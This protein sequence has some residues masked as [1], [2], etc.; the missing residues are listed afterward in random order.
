MRRASTFVVAIS[1]VVWVCG[2][3]SAG[4]RKDEPAGST[5]KP[6]APTRALAS[7][8][9]YA[10]VV[11]AD[12]PV[13]YWRLGEA[14][15]TTAADASG[16]GLS[17]TYVNG[18]SLGAP[19][20][21]IGD[22]DTAPSFDG[23]DDRV[24]RSSVT[25]QLA[26]VTIEA[27]VYWSGCCTSIGNPLIVYNGDSGANGYGI[28]ISAGFG[29]SCGTNNQLFVIQGGVT[30]DAAG[31]GGGLPTNQWT[32][33]AATRS[34]NGVWTIFVNGSTKNSRTNTPPPNPITSGGT[35]IAKEF[36]GSGG[37]GAFQGR[38]DEVAVYNTALSPA[39]IKAH[40][41]AARPPISQ[42]VEQ[43]YGT[44]NGRGTHALAPSATV[45]DP[46]NTLTGAFTESVEDLAVPG[47]G[48]SFALTRTYTSADA[49]VGRFGPGWTDSYSTSLMELG[50]G[51]VRLRG[52]EGQQVSF[53]KNGDGS[54]TAGAGV[55]STLASIAGG[56]RL[57]RHDQVVYEFDASGRLTSMNDRNGQ[58]LSFAYDASARLV[59]VT[60]AAG[61]QATVAYNASNLVSQVSLAGRSVAYGYTS[62]RLTSVTDVRGKTWT[63][64]YDA[65]GRLATIVDPLGHAQ[66]S[67]VYG[68]D[69]RV[70]SQTDAL[71]KTTTFAW[72]A[73]TQVATVTDANGKV[74]KDD[75]ENNVL[76]KRIDPLGNETVFG[77]DTDLNDTEVTGPSGETTTM[78]YDANGNV[79]SATAPASLG[80]VQKTFVYNPRNDPTSVTDARG[81]VTS[82]TYTPVGN[83]QTVTQDGIQVGSYTYGA[84]GRVLTSTDGNGKTTVYTYDANGNTA[85]VTDPLGNETSYT[86]DAAGRVLTRVD[87]R[88]NVAGANPADFTWS[89]THNA[90]GQVL[91]ETDPLGNTTTHTY[92]DAG[93]ESSLTDANGHTTTY[94]YDAENRLLS[95]R[96]P[97]PDGAGPLAAPITAYTY[98]SVGNK[99]T[100][101]DPRGNVTTFAYDAA[102]RL[103]SET[104]PDP[105][106]PGPLAGPV[107]TYAY[108][109]N[110]NLQSTVEPRGNAAGANPNEYRTTYTYDA[111]GRLLTQ[112][113][114]DP[115]GAGP[116]L[117]AVTTNTYDSVGNLTSV[118]DANNHTTAYTYDAAGGILTVTAPDG[119]LT[120]SS[121]DPAGNLLTRR[122]DNN[123][124]TTWAHDAAGRV[125]SETGPDPDGAGSAA[126]P[127]TS[128]GYDPNGN[129]VTLTDPNGNATPTAGDGRTS[130]GYDRA[131]R[132]TSIDYA[133]ATPDVAFTYDRVGNRLTM[134]DGAGTE[135]RTY[136]S[137]DRLL[138]VSRGQHTFSYAYDP[139]GNTLTRTYPGG[140][141]TSYT[142]D[143]LNRIQTVDAGLRTINLSY[144]PAGHVTQTRFGDTAPYLE[145]FRAY[146]RAGRLTRVA[147]SSVED[148]PGCGDPNICAPVPTTRSAFELTLDPV[149]NPT[150][151][152]R[153]G[154]LASTTTYAYDAS[155]RLTSVCFQASCPGASDPFIRWTYDRVGNRLNEQRP[156][157]T[158][159][160]T[161]DARDR[162]LS[163]GSVSY[164]YDQNGNA[165]S[166]GSRTFAHDL[167]NRLNTTILGNTTTSYSYDGDGVRLQAST[168]SA[169]NKKTNFLWDPNHELP[170]IALEQDGNNTALRTYVYGHRR[171]A[172]L[173]GSNT[174]YY[175]VDALGSVAQLTNA[176][177]TSPQWTY[178]YEPFGT[179][180]TQ[181]KNA[182]NA[183]DNLIKFTGEYHD[184]TGL[185]H[186]RARQYDSASARFL[187]R[188]PVEVD[189]LTPYGSSYAFVANRPTVMVDPSG[190][191]FTP[192]DAAQ[193]AAERVTSA[194]PSNVGPDASNLP[195]S[196]VWIGY[197]GDLPHFST[198]SYWRGE[199][200]YA[201]KVSW[202]RRLG[203]VKS[204]R[205]TVKLQWKSNGG[206]L[207]L[208]AP[209]A[210]TVPAG[211]KVT[212]T[213]RCTPNTV[214]TL[215]GA[216]D[217]D[218]INYK[219]PPGWQYWGVRRVPCSPP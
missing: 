90:A 37:A 74:W 42:S 154:D 52:D 39:R 102:N 206:W 113:N 68:A 8:H 189:S 59:S 118:K 55:L 145:E 91:T 58:G 54:F 75:Y 73:A 111:A 210:A 60:D 45:A 98:D 142:Y 152:E 166:A 129:R 201:V 214:K 126:A 34:G 84:A 114:P 70:T 139:V 135:T 180:R 119:G 108:D 80:G 202:Y 77:H 62:G 184:P 215:R 197:K 203:S 219:D 67:N 110:G 106:G 198:R 104:G 191:T 213:A 120:T 29:A 208:G 159:T 123:H 15:G 35:S 141:T 193:V 205:L 149:G 92:D 121:Y 161:Y 144:D 13:A 20:A 14:A 173:V 5:S 86:Y 175:T 93:N 97:D 10:D 48:V 168:G 170:Q 163:A 47:T 207:N 172:L 128:Y 63:Y 187:A 69:G 192:S 96:R 147:A 7:S 57:V 107:T 151:I 51:D 164:T 212:A 150:R 160:Y 88:G 133:D 99:L 157:G 1:L 125:V 50:N 148:V 4:P 3:A 95:E 17:G 167:A 146:D 162:L 190:Q 9:T 36:G 165:L 33:V 143:P 30:C 11:R 76:V 94:A 103:V 130:Y 171:L 19:G 25:T 218:I 32:H 28:Q 158:T 53:V 174:Y 156:S 12:A 83:V 66:I 72:D 27:W 2:T 137:L 186:L 124:T 44:V 61:R 71:G 105:D 21:V 18:V 188:D 195:T 194:I 22:P 85:S 117:A 138:S 199:H 122:D 209:N 134:A 153:S 109:A 24:E 87:P 132:L 178:S 78:S 31:S 185:Y 177:G 100:E 56:Y 116:Q 43:T 200:R 179:I 89:Y 131:N 26:N 41:D 16:N 23:G 140:V 115:D 216:V 155:D 38:I 204:V 176:D 183:P 136:D 46:V 181:T 64:S 217:S 6:A 127:L 81:K 112:T 65:D 196:A 211:T 169:A 79:L 82:Y 40:Y 49:T 101:T 182:G